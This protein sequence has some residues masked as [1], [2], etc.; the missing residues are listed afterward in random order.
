[1]IQQAQTIHDRIAVSE[2]IY[3]AE[4]GFA[5]RIGHTY[6]LYERDTGVRVLSLVAPEEWRKGPPFRFVAR[7]KLLSDHTWDVEAV[8]APG[9]GGTK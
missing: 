1:M 4:A 6:F 7:A 9:E 2:S 8:V 3:T 5:P